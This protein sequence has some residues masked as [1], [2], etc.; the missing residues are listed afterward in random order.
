M[1]NVAQRFSEVA[2]SACVFSNL[3]REEKQKTPSCLEE[4]LKK[5]GQRRTLEKWQATQNQFLHC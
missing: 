4:V 3:E 2:D 1:A 5:N